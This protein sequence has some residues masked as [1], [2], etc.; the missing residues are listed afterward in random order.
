MKYN[1]CA[2]LRKVSV[3][4]ASNPILEVVIGVKLCHQ[5][6]RFLDRTSNKLLISNPY[7]ILELEY[8]PLFFATTE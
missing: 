5:T 4:S 7:E 6:S 1:F 8:V 2:C 3:R